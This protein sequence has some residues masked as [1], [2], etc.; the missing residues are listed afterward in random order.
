MVG[1]KLV[2]ENYFENIY[3]HQ[4]KLEIG[5]KYHRE[6]IRQPIDD[7]LSL[8]NNVMYVNLPSSFYF[9]GD[10]MS[11]FENH[12]FSSNMKIIE[13][14]TDN[15]EE[16]MR[17]EIYAATDIEVIREV[18]REEIIKFI[19]LNN[20]VKSDNPKLHECA[21]VYGCGLDILIDDPDYRVRAA[22]ADSSYGLDKLINDK[23]GYVRSS[24]ALKGFG[25][26][27][28]MYDDDALVRSIVALQDYR[29][30]KFINDESSIVRSIVAQKGYGVDRLLKDPVLKVSRAAEKYITYFM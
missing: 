23:T 9:Y 3:N 10:L 25:L 12:E 21:A 29:L 11:L 28:L 6:F 14:N 24:V 1:Y 26:N 30:D 7:G 17:G 4:M 19:E 15:N 8:K 5:K 22:V 20:F 13:I 27:I 16:I 18:P 2:D